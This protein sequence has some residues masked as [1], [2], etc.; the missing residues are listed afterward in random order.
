[1]PLRVRIHS[2]LVSIMRES[3][4][5]GTTLSGTPIPVPVMTDFIL[6][7]TDTLVCHDRQDCLS[8]TASCIRLRR[9]RNKIVRGEAVVASAELARDVRSALLDHL[10]QLRGGKESERRERSLAAAG[11][12]VAQRDVETGVDLLVIAFLEDS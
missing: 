6:W 8:S 1:M 5:F 11:A 12:G 10:L 2:S 3:R 4:S 7:M 9:Q